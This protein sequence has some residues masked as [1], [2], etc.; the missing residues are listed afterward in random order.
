MRLLRPEA[1]RGRV[2]QALAN[3][4]N[5]DAQVGRLAFLWSGGNPTLSLQ[6]LQLQPKSQEGMSSRPGFSADSVRLVLD[7][8]TY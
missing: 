2:E 8:V 1:Q 6:K 5:A 3:S 7:S 4:F